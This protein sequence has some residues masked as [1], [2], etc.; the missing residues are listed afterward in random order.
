LSTNFFLYRNVCRHCGRGDDRVHIG[1]RSGGW[2]FLWRGYRDDPSVGTVESARD[3]SVLL[4]RETDSGSE[5]RDEY[6]TEWGLGEFEAMTIT[7]GLTPECRER[8]NSCSGATWE[9]DAEGCRVD[10]SEFR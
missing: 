6:G 3:W 9:R 1:K 5:I 2:S 4:S 8:E 10:F 7:W